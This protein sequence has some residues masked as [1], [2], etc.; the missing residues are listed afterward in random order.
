MP[1]IRYALRSLMQNP[2]FT[3]T[4]VLCL[5]LGLGANTAIFSVVKAALLFEIPVESPQEMMLVWSSNPSRERTRN[6][7]SVN[8]FHDF[9]Q[10]SRSFEGMAAYRGATYNLSGGEYPVRAAGMAVTGDYFD[11]AGTQAAQGRLLRESDESQPGGVVL[12]HR[13]CQRAFGSCEGIVGRTIRLNGRPVTVV[14]VLPEGFWFPF[15]G[16]ELYTPLALRPASADRGERSL[17]VTGRLAENVSLREAQS[18]L[19]GLAQRLSES[20][21]QTN[22]GWQVRVVPVREQLVAGVST[23]LTLLFG[24]VSFVLLIVC[25]NVGNLFLARSGSRRREI[26]VRKALGAGRLSIAGQLLT[27]GALLSLMGAVPGLALAWWGTSQLQG[28]FAGIPFLAQRMTLDLRVLGYLGLVTLLAPLL[29]ALAPALQGSRLDIVEGLKSG[30]QPS[31]GGPRRLRNA[32][33]VS[34]VALSLTLLVCVGL[35]LRTLTA[36]EEVELGFQPDR[37]LVAD[38]AIPERDGGPSQLDLREAILGRAE[39]LPG[40]VRAGWISSPPLT[41]SALNPNREISLE[42]QGRAASKTP[43]A[44]GELVASRGYFEA[45]AIP[46]ISGRLY[47]ESGLQDQPPV[48]VVSQTLAR[49]CWPGKEALGKRFKLGASDSS[50]PWIEVIGVVGDVI[51][52]DRDQPS[53]PLAYRPVSQRPLEELSLVLRSQPDPMTLA[54]PLRGEISQ[55]LPDQPVFNI[56]TMED[57]VQRDLAGAYLIIHMMGLLALTALALAAVGLYGVMAHLS[58][59][60]TYELGIRM[61][62]GA[63]RTRILRLVSGQALVLV[64][65]G[66]ALGALLAAAA[67]QL[68][69]DQLYQVSPFDPLTFLATVLLLLSAALPASILPAWRASRTDPLTALRAD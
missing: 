68:L 18:E 54:D 4:A 37:L 55:V 32:L 26:A 42:G 1:G 50:S 47:E 57:I 34:E 23:G 59:Q 27:E 6:L 38:V 36:L 15:P 58:R 39:A 56:R 33:V 16:A 10:Q 49:R 17:V 21:P 14:G 3:L 41:G 22:R 61:A 69:A 35:F 8:D 2:G 20:Y 43:P 62:L 60:R 24:A 30:R 51:N 9:R 48:A 52:D 64:L 44:A 53:L 28:L 46:L 65:A 7:V 19:T 40:A 13:L 12:A 29:F 45:L 25:A 5:G 63:G 31:S 66:S 67:A 11:L